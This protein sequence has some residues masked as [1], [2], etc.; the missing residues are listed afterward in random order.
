[1]AI[2]QMKDRIIKIATDY[3]LFSRLSENGKKTSKEFTEEKKMKL[4][5]RIIRDSI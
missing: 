4:L 1:M 2:D 3:E 5:N